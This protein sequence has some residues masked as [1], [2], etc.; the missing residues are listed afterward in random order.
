M[1]PQR[2]LHQQPLQRGLQLRHQPRERQGHLHLPLGV[3]GAGLQPGRGR[4]LA[5]CVPAGLRGH[6]GRCWGRALPSEGSRAGRRPASLGDHTGWAA[7][8]PSPCHA[9]ALPRP[10]PC[11]AAHRAPPAARQAPTPASTKAG[12]STRWAPSS[13]G[14]CRATPGP[15]ARSTS[16]SASRTRVRTT[17]PAWT[18][19]GSSSASVCPVRGAGLRADPAGAHGGLERGGVGELGLRAQHGAG[20]G[21][22]AA[23]L[24]RVGGRS[25]PPGRG[26]AARSRRMRRPQATRASTAR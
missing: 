26:E 25:R 7:S 11:R 20:P 1:P 5:G 24:S 15:A 21:V 14:V 8:S 6:R 18:R 12:A 10:S 2:R 23:G 9:L 16:T 4:V 19:S 22:G 17:P 3:H 13:A